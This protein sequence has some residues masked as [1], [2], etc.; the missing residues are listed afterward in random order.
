M[1]GISKKR[2]WSCL[3]LILNVFFCLHNEIIINDKVF[4]FFFDRCL[5]LIKVI[6]SSFKKPRTALALNNFSLET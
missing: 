1:E 6:I 3:H 5:L 4:V 2:F